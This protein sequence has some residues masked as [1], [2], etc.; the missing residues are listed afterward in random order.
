MQLSIIILAAFVLD[1]VIGDPEYSLHPVRIIGHAISKLE[2]PLRKIPVNETV[3]GTLF[4]VAVIVL[5]VSA[6]TFLMYI[7]AIIDRFAPYSAFTS[8]VSIY[9]MYSCISVHDLKKRSMLIYTHLKNNEL[10]LARESLSMIVGRETSSLSEK[11][12]VRATVETVAENMVD[13]IISPLAF[14]AIGGAPL[15]VFYKAVNTLDSMVG[16]KNEKYRHFGT[17]SAKLDDVLNFIPARASIVLVSIAAFLCN[18]LFRYSFSFKNSLVAALKDG[19]KN[20]SP[21]SGYSEAAAAGALGIQLGGVNVYHNRK[22]EKPLIGSALH[23][24]DKEHI[25]HINRLMYATSLVSLF[26][27]ILF[28]IIV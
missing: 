1:L 19:K 23:E 10:E 3:G 18:I 6:V 20:P 5:S 28:L 27:S 17:F 8:V 26:L 12:V 4:G 25:V 22:V 13:G 15:A 24:L 11:E 7:A 16:Y 21:N 2:G 9:F 14:A